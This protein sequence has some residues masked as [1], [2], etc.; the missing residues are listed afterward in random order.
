M[1]DLAREIRRLFEAMGPNGRAV[2]EE[3][4]AVYATDLRF[5][6]P[7]QVTTNIDDFLETMGRLMDRA[8]EL[9]FEV[10]SQT[11]AADEIFLTWTMTFA[12]K[13]GP[14][15]IVDGVSHLRAREGRIVFQRDYW[16][17]ANLFASTV[18][19]GQRILRTVL[20]PLT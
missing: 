13:L 5:E 14:R 7:M 16:D 4:R 8:R 2:L 20:R 12:P 17:L 19:G 9:S 11:E 10:H 6:D 18:P 1:S 3:C 15:S